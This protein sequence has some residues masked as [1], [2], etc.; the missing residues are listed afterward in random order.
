MPASE[1]TDEGSFAAG[2]EIIGYINTPYDEKFAVPRQPGLAPH[3]L[4]MIV[5]NPPYDDPLAFEGLEG[6]SHI[7]VIFLFDRI[8]KA[9]FSARVRPPRLGGNRRIGVFASRSP[10]RPSRIGLSV[11][12]LEKIG[13]NSQGGVFLVVS[14]ADLTNRTPIIDIKPYVPFVDAVT[15][16]RGGFADQPPK[17]HEVC[18]SKKALDDLNDLQDFEIAA[19]KET[20]AQDP[21]PAYKNRGEDDKV[22]GFGMYRHEIRF[23]VYAGTV[24]VES[25]DRVTDPEN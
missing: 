9:T 2:I 18:F 5:F 12:K 6:F 24:L 16:A 19:V 13:R 7:H 20:L 21:R 14:G 8:K 22:Y 23:K 10:F 25:G 17:L 1:K 4:S 3:A 11:M 15:D